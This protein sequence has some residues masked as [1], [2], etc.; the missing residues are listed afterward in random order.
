MRNTI[1]LYGDDGLAVR[2]TAA[3]VSD[4]FDLATDL[5]SAAMVTVANGLDQ[6]VTVTVQG[7]NEGDTTW[8]TAGTV[9]VATGASGYYLVDT[10]W[11]QVRLSSVAAGIPTTGVLQARVAPVPAA[12]SATAVG[13]TVDISDRAARDLG[14]VD[15]AGIDAVGTSAGQAAMAASFPVVVASDQSDVPVTVPVGTAA[16]AASTPVT[17]ASDDTI[18]TA[19]QTAVEILDNAIAGTE[20]QVDVATITAG[21]THVGQVGGEGDSIIQ[22]PTVTAGAYTANDNVGGLL[23]FAN[24]ARVSGGTGVIKQITIVDDASQS[25]DLEL[26]LLDQTFTAGADNAVWTP[27]E[28]E[29]HNL[30]T[31]IS[32]TD[33][34][35]FTAG[36]TGTVCVVEVARHYTLTGTSLFGRLVTRGTPT[37]VAT[38]DVSAIVHLM[39]D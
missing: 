4:L 26:W 24:A 20:M 29:L 3:Q 6:N 14:K 12:A 35:W 2:V 19:I 16:M 30:V 38:D 13:A 39:Q 28:A 21:E 32:T 27:V 31:V 37:Y 17:V 8:Q 18:M 34:T 15:V 10:P 23:T 25:A 5:K 1:E 11:G 36:A 22:T 9:V 33:G 7:R